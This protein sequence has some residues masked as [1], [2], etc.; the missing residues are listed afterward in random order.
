M[1]TKSFILG[2]I[3]ALSIWVIFPYFFIKLNDYFSFPIINYFQLRIIGILVILISLSSVVYSTLIFKLKGEGTPIPTEPPKKLVIR[4]LFKYTRN[5]MYLSHLLVF[6]GEF[7]I[8]GRILLL[9]YLILAFFG[10]NL[11]VTKW[12]EP[13]LKKR[14]GIEYGDYLK[15]VPRWL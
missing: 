7:L 3:F 14:F 10:F 8:F 2:I 12:E 4:G 11:L 6:L 9:L 15:K 13:Q 1:K 5:P